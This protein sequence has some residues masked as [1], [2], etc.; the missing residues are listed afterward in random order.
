MK[1]I[2]KNI[3]TGELVSIYDFGKKGEV[4]VTTEKDD[5]E[6]GAK[7]VTKY[8]NMLTEGR[9]ENGKQFFTLNEG[10]EVVAG[11]RKPRK[12]KPTATTDEVVTTS[13]EQPQQEVVET[14]NNDTPTTTPTTT[15]DE[16]SEIKK[17]LRCK[18]GQIGE[19][20]VEAVQMITANTTPTTAA[21]NNVSNVTIVTTDNGQHEVE[22]TTCKDF[23]ALC[24]TIK[25]GINLYLY[26]E[27]GTGKSHTCKQIAQALGLAYYPM[28]QL[29]YAHEVVGYA[30]ADGSLVETPFYKAFT[31]GGLVDLEEFDSSS[32]EAALVING[33]IAN[34]VC[35]FPVVGVKQAH[36]DF[37][38]IATGNTKMTGADIEYTGRSV[39]DA[40][41]KNRFMFREVCYDTKIED[42][43]TN[44]D[45]SISKF[46]RDLRKAKN[47]AQITLCVSYRSI[48]MLAD[49]DMQQAWG[50]AELLRGSVFKELEQDEIQILYTRLEDKKNRWAVAMSK[51]I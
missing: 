4:F 23:A 32:P 6:K 30:T 8:T 3:E 25:K 39:M 27:A 50:D 24:M 51:L 1:T 47:A 33:A 46:C 21:V 10:W 38:V 34:K 18:Y 35:N 41:T 37:R 43:L 26:G 45:L 49:K 12:P 9:D 40:S 5:R 48:M 16:I 29:L 44:G 7:F 14:T 28:Q 11:E 15:S 17:T 19:D 31:E 2:F 22:G 20:F 13:N 36:P 42:S